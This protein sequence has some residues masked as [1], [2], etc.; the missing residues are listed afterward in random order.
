MTSPGGLR[1]RKKQRTREAIQREAMRLF[2]EQGYDE[3]TIEQIAAAADISPSTFFNYFPSKEAVVAYDNY[4]PRLLASVAAG[5]PDEPLSAAILRAM[6]E[7]TGVFDRD[8][9]VILARARLSLEVPELRARI[10]GELERTQRQLCEI[11]AAR[12]GRDADDFELRVVTVALLAA[13]FEASREWVRGRGREDMVEMVERAFDALEA[14]AQGGSLA[15][16]A[17]SGPLLES[18]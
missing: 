4:D 9:E 3:T 12:S 13:A 18:S 14:S 8:R 1:E 6:K 17:K 10:W 16:P 11:F 2:Q 7:M 15:R 5:P